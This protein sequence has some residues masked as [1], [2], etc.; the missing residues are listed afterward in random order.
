MWSLPSRSLAA[1]SALALLLIVQTSRVTAAASNDP[2][3]NV[4]LLAN[5]EFDDGMTGWLQYATPDPAY[6]HTQITNGVLEFYR[7]HT[8]VNGRQ[9]QAVVFQWTWLTMPANAPL[10]AAFDL[11]NS[12]N[13]RKRVSVLI[14]DGDFSD[15]RVCTFWLAP[16]AP[17]QTYRMRTFSRQAWANTTFSFYA[18]SPDSLGG[19]YQADNVSLM[20][21][22]GGATDR[23]LCEDPTA[24]TAAGGP[25]GPTLLSNGDFSTG[26]GPWA[27]F[28]R[29]TWQITNGVFE[30]IW[31]Y[32]SADGDGPT[33]PE[34]EPAPTVI[35]RTGQTMAA[36]E[37]LQADV[38]LGNS[39]SVWK[40]V[41]VLMHDWDFSDLAACSF[42]LAPGAPR[43]TYTMR[44]FTTQA[45]SDAALSVYA[46]TQGPETW[47]EVD[48]AVFR[49]TPGKTTGGKE[50]YEPGAQPSLRAVDAKVAVEPRAA[51]GFAS[52]RRGFAERLSPSSTRARRSASDASGV[53]A[54]SLDW[55]GLLQYALS[56]SRETRLLQVSSDGDEWR[57]VLVADPS[58]DWRVVTID[59]SG[60]AGRVLY[61]RVLSG[62]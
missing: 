38:D 9:N 19:F 45:W 50:C 25:D 23:T 42:W 39:S 34:P 41:T 49:R 12:S 16:N 7:D 11:G 32:P 54:G 24:P 44:M 57:T 58:D 31:P 36:G 18:A 37:I 51:G 56:P 47:I 14:H 17:L 52:T 27:V 15:L 10:V 40:R 53:A 46:A 1:V 35:Q 55:P 62:S 26:L 2:T 60:P 20:Y 21:D 59:T 61:V 33:I 3:P 13:V 30:F 6:I 29:A 4:N 28:H 8:L 5:G 43:E 22:P 48:N